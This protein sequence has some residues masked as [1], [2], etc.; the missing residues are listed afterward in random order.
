MFHVFQTSPFSG[1]PVK[2]RVAGRT[3]TATYGRCKKTRTA[4]VMLD[5]IVEKIINVSNEHNR[6]RKRRKRK[7]DLVDDDTDHM[8]T[9]IE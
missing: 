3:M 1:L 8:C 7:R 4:V 5:E 6:R 9:V 2:T